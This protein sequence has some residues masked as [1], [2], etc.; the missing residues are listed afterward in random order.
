MGGSLVSSNPVTTSEPERTAAAR[1]S[2]LDG[3][4]QVAG[5]YDEMLGQ[6]GL[7]REHWQTLIGSLER[8]GPDEFAAR[9]ETARRVLREHGVSY[10]VYGDAQGTDRPWGVDLVPMLISAPEW[11]TIDAGLQQRTRLLNLILADLYGRQQLLQ[12]GWIPSALVYANPGFLRPCHGFTPPHDLFLAVHAVDLARS[13]DGQWRVLADRTQAPSGIGYALENRLVVARILPEEFRDCQ[14]QRLAEFFR[15]ERDTLRSLAARNVD[16][17]NVVLLTPGPFN[18]TYF[19][20]VFLA[21]YLGFP[22]V[23]GGDL[24]VRDRR[25][26][27]KTLEGLQ[28]VEV[29]LR[30]VD[31]TYCDPL[32]FRTDSFL[33]V[34]GLVEA[35]RAGNVAIANALGSGAVEAPALMPFLPGLC[36]HLLGEELLLPSVATWWCGE[37]NERRYV[38]EHLDELVVKQAFTAASGDPAFGQR[39]GDKQRSAL[40]S[41]I[42]AAPTQFVAQ[43]QIALGCAPVWT[44]KG[45]EPRPLVLRT[46]VCASGEGFHVLP[47]GLTRVS[48]APDQLVVSIQSGGGSKDTWVLADGPVPHATLLLPS[49]QVV[50]L[51]RAA[52]EVPSRVADNL[53]W[54]GR[55]AERLEDTV[56]VLRCLLTRLTGEAGIDEAPE[57]AAL[58]ELLVHLDLFPARFRERHTL[59]SVEREILL[60]IYQQHR[61]GTVREVMSRLRQ[62][63]FVLRDRFSADTWSVL[64]KLQ[65]DAGNRM[66]QVPAAEALLLLNTLIV[67]LAA[68]SGMEMENMTRGHGWHF[69]DIGRRL[70]RAVN[71][72]TLLQ[73][74]TAISAQGASVLEPSLEI[75]DS[76]MTY[77]RRYFAQ[78]QLGPV[79][80]LLAADETNP[81]SM[82]FQLSSLAAHVTNLPRQPSAGFP[83]AE[84]EQIQTVQHRLNHLQAITSA[85]SGPDTQE[86]GD[87]LAACAV[88][89]RSVSNMLT[90]R[91]FSHADTRA[92]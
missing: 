13:P 6:P 51:E 81:R 3:Y 27:I 68:F 56:R 52:A 67:D 41:A 63:A 48:A 8:L 75:A 33:G 15:A 50:R 53:Y 7:P 78:P 31:D 32:E 66:R 77:R 29:I 92:S 62:I 2:L 47:G 40:I 25:V 37:E 83:S 61:L 44:R 79:L 90:H 38:L 19:E 57:V 71:V 59:A 21:R 23:E 69:L 45:L 49:H 74:A 17:P 72:A 73:G 30:R 58:I 80:D 82:A 43:E 86:V 1:R 18:E 14:V 54:L 76:L 60:L 36:R 4:L 46:F 35:A 12:D 91:Y 9:G 24:T 22:L 26:F 34:P 20:H 39:L 70:E 42:Q 65:V 5:A 89:L 87:V 55:Y 16:R 85:E 11:R 64:N 28:P 88:G 10:N 84:V